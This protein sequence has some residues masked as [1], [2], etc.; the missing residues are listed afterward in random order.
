[1]R[2]TRVAVHLVLWVSVLLAASA[3]AT[4][5]PWNS[6]GPTERC[7]QQGLSE[8]VASRFEAGST[9]EGRF[10]LVPFGLVCDYHSGGSVV[11][12]PSAPLAS[13][14]VGASSLVFVGANGYL[15]ASALRGRRSLRGQ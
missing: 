10:A 13:A 9:V 5:Q 7:L 11:S 2:G 14:F 3:V 8:G 4:L 12:V 15:V 1:M 6:A